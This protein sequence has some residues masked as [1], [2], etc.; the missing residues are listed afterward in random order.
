MKTTEAIAIVGMGCRF[1]GGANDPNAYWELLI[2][3]IDAISEVPEDRWNLRSHFNE[4]KTK[5]GKTYTRCGGFIKDIDKFDAD[6]FGISPREAACMDPQQRIL[7]ETTWEAFA[8]AGIDTERLA[9][10]GVGTFM[11]IFTHDY[12]NM[13]LDTS[14]RELIDT[15]TGVGVSM[16][17]VAN[18]ISY[19]FDFT[20]PSVTLDTACSSSLVALH[21][22]CQSIRNGECE[23]AIAGGANAILKPEFTIA[24]SKASMLSPDGRCKSFDASANGYVRSEGAGVVILKPLSAAQKDGDSIYAVIKSSVVNQDGK[25]NGLTVPNQKSQK[26]ALRK[27]LELA[28]VAAE[29]I[30][31]VEA[32]GTG[33]FVGDPIEANSIGSVFGENRKTDLV[34]GSVKSNIGHLEAASGMA[35]LIKV[36]MSLKNEMIPPNI[37]FKMPNPQI[38]FDK[39]HLHV[40]VVPETWAAD[41]DSSRHACV[42]S[43]GFGGTNATIILAESPQR[44]PSQSEA[45]NKADAGSSPFI[46]PLS[47][48][49]PKALEAVVGGIRSHLETTDD[50]LSDICFSA[51]NRSGHKDQRVAFIASDKDKML[52]LTAQFLEGKDSPFIVKGSNRYTGGKLA[53]IFSGMGTQWWAMGR[54]LI[55][56]NALFRET[57]E[58]CDRLLSQY[59][60]WSLL[61]ELSRSESDTRI[62]GTQFAQPAIFAVEVA[63]AKLWQSYG[64]VPDVVCGH[65]VG[66]VAAAHISGALSLEDAVK[67]IFYRSLLQQKTAGMGGMLAVSM[68]KSDAAQLIEKYNDRVSIA[69]V[70]SPSSVT[71]AG[72]SDALN[73]LEKQLSADNIFCRPLR[74]EVPFHCVVMDVIKDELISLLQS[75]APNETVI[76]LYST[77]TGN[78]ISGTELNADYWWHN[79]REPVEFAKTIKAME[80]CDVF[81]EVGPHPVLTQSMNECLSARKSAIVL[82]TIKRQQD[83]TAAMFSTFGALHAEGYPVNWTHIVQ[84]QFVKLPKYPWQRQAYWRESEISAQ[85]RMGNMTKRTL[86]LEEA[87]PLLGNK[88][89]LAQVDSIWEAEIQTENLPFLTGHNVHDAIVFPGAGFIEMALAAVFKEGRSVQVIEHFSFEKAL[90]LREEA[91]RMQSVLSQNT[92]SIYSE[93][94]TPGGA[95]TWIKHASVNIAGHHTANESPEFD[96]AAIRQ[97]CTSSKSKEEVYEAFTNMGFN[98]QGDFRRI[99]SFQYTENEALARIELGSQPDRI[100]KIYPPLLDN[101]FQALLGIISCAAGN[102]IQNRVFLPVQIAKIIVHHRSSTIGTEAWCHAVITESNEQGLKGNLSIYDN[103]GKLV[104]SIEELFCVS[105]EKA[106]WDALLLQNEQDSTSQWFNEVRW[107]PST[108][109]LETYTVSPRQWIIFGDNAGHGA[110]LT[111][112]LLAQ[113]HDAF[114]V[115]AGTEFR[116]CSDR[117]FQI[118]VK[119]PDDFRELLKL[120]KD[121]GSSAGIVYLW[122][123]DV[124]QLDQSSDSTCGCGTLLYLIQALNSLNLEIPLWIVTQGGQFIYPEASRLE[125]APMW[126]FAQVISLEQ[127]QLQCRCIDLDPEADTADNALFLL[128]VLN[129]DSKESRLAFRNGEAHTA[130]LVPSQFAIGKSGNDDGSSISAEATYLITGA[131]GGL[132]RLVVQRLVA[133]GARHLALMGRRGA[134]GNEDFVADLGRAGVTCHVAVA[135]VSVRKDVE[136]VVNDIKET[137]PP[138]HGIIHAA[139]VLDDGV[140]TQQSPERFEKIMQPKVQ[141]SWNLHELTVDLP[142]DFF[143]CFSSVASLVGSPG[144]SNYAAGNAFM[145]LL[146]HSRQSVGL[147]AL[148]INWGPWVGEGMAAT[149]LKR[150]ESKG[151]GAIDIE[152]GLQAFEQLISEPNIAQIGVAPINWETFF[153]AFP[154]HKNSFFSKFI[155]KSTTE[156]PGN[157]DFLKQLK[158]VIEAEQHHFLLKHIEDV[159]NAVFGYNSSEST[160]YRKSLF[161]NGLDSLMAL[162]IKNRLESSLRMP[163][164]STLL[165][166]HPTVESLGDFLSQQIGLSTGSQSDSAASEVDELLLDLDS[167]TDEELSA[168]L[169]NELSEIINN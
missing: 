121:A 57:I 87:H 72:E 12:N 153:S 155:E 74:V 104:I 73:A 22:A 99:G 122:P 126:G 111:S 76:P 65:S 31:Y 86:L 2:N 35:S 124:L 78:L 70:N 7:L 91:V 49:T 137:M 71:L 28:D 77:V 24:T 147:P 55:E 21:L 9:G 90:V 98:Y 109:E 144:Q 157:N 17:I 151:F 79:V 123:L 167:L 58:T 161:D 36:A 94:M 43:F 69:A 59:A 68:P 80:D 152:P 130:R 162:E 52:D 14:N 23:V 100:Y 114:S 92:F 81:L 116:Q 10:T 62:N 67:V 146:A 156:E 53:F 82:G 13:Q 96:L 112:K 149:Q 45:V 1:P 160:D 102:R 88:I 46:L 3:G 95:S 93:K 164:Q 163:L 169:E 61:E 29:E 30:S 84:G 19:A 60:S 38:E 39:Y 51:A 139:G 136:R 135:D 134:V 33:T 18:R 32:H 40:P 150:L 145:D 140:I 159:V 113:G 108:S 142:L 20:G 154:A 54:Q 56:E 127:P 75:I 117:E 8:D 6:F 133:N 129:S 132:G 27:A 166:E 143:V 44:Q 48:N 83:E 47:A 107:M 101:G 165:F 97:R 131:F 138:L 5:P 26:A 106:K 158:E 141:G 41:P 42:N 11:G 120:V 15:H 37:H 118:S 66:E 25:S 119:Q 115:S 168:L 16:S 148:S 4:D 64:I 63:L 85:D 110:Q 125:Q 34:I 50:S 103:N 89:A 105:V 128:Q